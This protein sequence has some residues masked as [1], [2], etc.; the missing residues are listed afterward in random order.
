[1]SVPYQ[2]IHLVTYETLRKIMNPSGTYSPST[3]FIAGAG[4]GALAAAITTPFD[5]AKTLLNT[6]EVTGS[7]RTYMTGLPTAMRTIYS[8]GGL[9][10]FAKGL[11]ARVAFTAPAAAISW[12]VYEF[13]KHTLVNADDH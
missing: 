9:S 8:V 11:T 10:G 3:H 13:F 1:M 7:G 2:T 4:A 5:V 12:S 6:Q